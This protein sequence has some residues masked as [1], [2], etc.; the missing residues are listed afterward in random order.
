MNKL[1]FRKIYILIIIQIIIEVACL[2][3]GCNFSAETNTISENFL[4]IITKVQTTNIWQ[5][6]IWCLGNNVSVMFIVFWLN[7]WTWGI[8]GTFWSINSSFCLGI[9]VKLCLSM[10][11]YI[12]VCFIILEWMASII[13]VMSTTY[14]RFIRREIDKQVW[15]IK[16][17]KSMGIIAG[18]L[19][20]A[21]VL[22]AI[23]LNSI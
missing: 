14:F 5:N 8:F 11:L 22:E 7:Y 18:L 21:A 2:I 17:L 6:F 4:E 3:W 1:K 9:L 10:N 23:A 15:Q 12:A 19:T 16:I 20:I 13:S